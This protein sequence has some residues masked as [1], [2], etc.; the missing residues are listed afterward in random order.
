MFLSFVYSTFIYLC[1]KGTPRQPLTLYQDVEEGLWKELSY[2][3]VLAFTL[4]A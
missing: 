4:Q 2:F 1:M 3:G